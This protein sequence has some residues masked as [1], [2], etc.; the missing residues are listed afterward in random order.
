MSSFPQE[1]D[2][3]FELLLHLKYEDLLNMCSVNGNILNICNS[4]LF[5]NE[6]YERDFQQL[7]NE[8]YTYLQTNDFKSWRELYVWTYLLNL[9]YYSQIKK[10][11]SLNLEIKKICSNNLFW[12]EKYEKDYLRLDNYKTIF[13]QSVG[14][15]WEDT[16]RNA[17]SISIIYP[18]T[19]YPFD[20]NDLDELYQ[21]NYPTFKSN[22]PNDFAQESEEAIGTSYGIKIVKANG[23]II[24]VIN[25]YGHNFTQYENNIRGILLNNP[26]ILLNN[27]ED[28]DTLVIYLFPNETAF[29][30]NIIRKGNKYN[31]FLLKSKD[32]PF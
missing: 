26:L 23:K 2:I 29:T 31:L 1:H 11:C 24:P 9:K 15:S 32:A 21:G 14:S 28:G 22:D 5:W 19:I 4:D 8:R 16:Y 27:L 3:N 12:R 20:D 6:K 10:L 25:T 7:G 13:E 18:E 30:E 17:A